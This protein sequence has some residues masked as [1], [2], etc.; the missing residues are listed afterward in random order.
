MITECSRLCFEGGK[1]SHLGKGG[2]III[3]DVKDLKGQEKN[4]VV[5]TVYA[6]PAHLSQCY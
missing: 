5:T 6:F 2:K 4:K 1:G 3:R